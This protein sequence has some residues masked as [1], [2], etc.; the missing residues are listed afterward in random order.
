MKIHFYGKKMVQMN[1]TEKQLR[2]IFA[3]LDSCVSAA[4]EN[5]QAGFKNNY[6]DVI[7]FERMLGELAKRAKR[8]KE[9]VLS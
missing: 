5:K 3:A 8:A 7:V 6:D 4:I 1:I 2:A 9:A